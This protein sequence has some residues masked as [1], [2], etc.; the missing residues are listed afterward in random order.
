MFAD[1]PARLAI[2]SVDMDVV[3]VYLV[4]LDGYADH[5][6]AW[7]RITSQRMKPVDFD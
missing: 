2:G 7:G 4:Q 1:E 3:L 6:L 5:D